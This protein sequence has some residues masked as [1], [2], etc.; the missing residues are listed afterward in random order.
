MTSSESDPEALRVT[1]RLARAAETVHGLSYYGPEINRFTDDGFRGWWHAYFAYRLAPAGPVNQAT[2]TALF[3]NFAP[4]MVARAVP[5]IWDI[6][7][8]EQVLERRA[9]LV[10]QIIER[11]FGDGE[12]HETVVEAAELATEAVSDLNLEARPLAAAHTELS[13]PDGDAMA[14]WHATTVWREYRGDSHNIALAAAGIDGPAS[15]LLMIASGRGN[16]A[17]I[18]KIR[19]WKDEEWEHSAAELQDR[20]VID[21]AGGFTERGAAFR[22]EIEDNTDRLSS[23]P[24]LTLGI[25]RAER[26]SALMGSL[27]EFLKASG[28]VAG[29]WPPPTVGGS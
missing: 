6:M 1:R 26:L 27:S 21:E 12:H 7:T 24:L 25:K 16:R 9:E 5:G 10:G 29:A 23:A 2:A 22:A 8:P 14:L 3:Y 18:G 17:I 19:G 20:G 15:H 4:R 13:W 11:V 28:E